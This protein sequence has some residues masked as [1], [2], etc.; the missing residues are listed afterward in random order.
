MGATLLARDPRPSSTFSAAPHEAEEVSPPQRAQL[1]M[2]EQTVPTF[3]SP[4]MP[5]GEVML[6]GSTRSGRGDGVDRECRAPGS[7]AASTSR[8]F[9]LFFS[10]VRGV[11]PQPCAGF[12]A[13]S[14]TPIPGRG[15]SGT[16]SE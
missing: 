5:S 9:C 3:D 4:C 8:G 2:L 10:A 13:L 7:S 16:A 1:G 11:R 15:A 12:Y 6:R 14:M